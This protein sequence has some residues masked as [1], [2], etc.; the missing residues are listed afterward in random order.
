MSQRRPFQAMGPGLRS[1]D[2][3]GEGILEMETVSPMAL[4]GLEAAVSTPHPPQ[5]LPLLGGGRPLHTGMCA[6]CSLGGLSLSRGPWEI[7][8]PL[9]PRGPNVG[10][11]LRRS[12]LSYPL[13]RSGP[14]LKPCMQVSAER[15]GSL[16]S[17]DRLLGLVK[18]AARDGA[19][20]L[21]SQTHTVIHK[22]L[23]YGSIWR[24][25][26]YTYRHACVLR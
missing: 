4:S 3:S 18:E 15:P 14:P 13:S 7:P 8:P 6:V 9:G 25:S 12:A 5:P 2:L 23:I 24:R 26:T 21:C 11:G 1:W 19:P 16:P 22:R 20:D 10:R 17:R